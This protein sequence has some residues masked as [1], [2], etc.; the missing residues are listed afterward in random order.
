MFFECDKCDK[1][2][3]GVSEEDLFSKVA[4]HLEEKH[5]TKMNDELKKKILHQIRSHAKS[6][7][8]AQF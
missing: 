4:V 1:I 2:L 8:P 6:S 5:D 3:R 7:P